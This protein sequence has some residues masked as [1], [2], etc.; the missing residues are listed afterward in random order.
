[1]AS[2]RELLFELMQAINPRQKP[3]TRWR[4]AALIS[5]MIEGS[6]LI[7]GEGRLQHKDLKGLARET[8]RAALLL[9]YSD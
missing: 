9:A 8:R 1:M 2:Y 3:A 5:T 7:V 6:L 4:R